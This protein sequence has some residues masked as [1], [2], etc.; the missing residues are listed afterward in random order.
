VLVDAGRG[1]AEGLRLAGIPVSQP[2]TLLLTNLLPTN[3]VGLDDLLLTGWLARREQPLRVIGPTGVAALVDALLLGHKSGIDAQRQGLGISD[4]GA[5]IEVLEVDS[6]WRDEIGELRVRAGAL[7]GGPTPAL[8]YLFENRGRSVVVSGTGWAPEDLI[9]FS[10][11]VDMLVHEAVYVPT[12]ED[13]EAAGVIGD[14]E[15]LLR[16]AA[17]HTSILDVGHL[18]QRAGVSTLVLV[19]LRP[20]PFFDIQVTGVVGNTFSGSVV[21]PDDGDE[22]EP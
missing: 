17:L 21:I 15:L 4:S 3:T 2:D 20:P 11:G 10:Q 18:G 5:Q 22:L 12:P 7:R 6:G 19:R 1:V 9:S 14:P 8:A 13:A 16:D